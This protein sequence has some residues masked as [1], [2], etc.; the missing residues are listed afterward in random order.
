MMMAAL[1]RCQSGLL[2]QNSELMGDKTRRTVTKCSAGDESLALMDDY[3]ARA[4][5]LSLEHV[6][7]CLRD[8]CVTPPSSEFVNYFQREQ[9]R[10]K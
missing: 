4:A 3:T 6:V 2:G 5:R 8:A 1:A 7:S 10:V 9:T